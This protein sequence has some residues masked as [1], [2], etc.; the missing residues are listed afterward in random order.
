MELESRATQANTGGLNSSLVIAVL[1]DDA[2]TISLIKHLLAMSKQTRFDINVIS[3]AYF[4]ASQI[5]NTD[6]ILLDR[7]FGQRPYSNTVSDLA[8]ARVDKPL[9]AIIVLLDEAFLAD[10]LR[11]IASSV[12]TGVDDFILT[13]ELSL[14]RILELI[15]AQEPNSHVVTQPKPSMHAAQSPSTLASSTLGSSTHASSNLAPPV[16]AP[17]SPTTEREPAASPIVS[18]EAPIEKPYD[19]PLHPQ[20]Q[21]VH[22]LSIDLENRRIHLSQNEH[23][24]LMDEA[25]AIV[26]IEEWLELLDAEGAKS[27]HSMLQRA[28]EFLSVPK[29]ISCTIKSKTGIVYPA[30]ITEI[31]IKENGQGRVV[32][33][34]AQILIG[35]N[36]IASVSGTHTPY[37][38]FDNLDDIGSTPMVDKVW[39]NI[40]ESLPMMCMVL[41]QNGYIVRV[42]NSDRSSTHYFPEAHV[43]Q[44]LKD[45]FG[46]ES[47][48]NYVESI[49]KTLNTG[50][51]HQQ[52]IAYSS[53]NGA[54]WFDTFITKMRG[55]LG[56]SRQVVWTAF[57]ATA[58]RQAY[59]E[60]LKNHDSLT[61]TL[62]DA[63]VIFCQKDA[64]GRYQRVNRTFCETFN[65]RAEV[66][67]GRNDQDIFKGNTLDQITQQDKILAEQGG[68]ASFIQTETIN[69]QAIAI[70]WHKFALKGHSSN[71]VESIAAFG[72]VSNNIQ[73]P[74]TSPSPSA[75]TIANTE[76]EQFTATMEE[77]SG[78]I[79]QDTKAIIK[80]IVSYT[81]IAISQK[82]PGRETRV[83]EYLNQVVNASERARDLIIEASSQSDDNGDKQSIELKPLV[84]DIVHMLKPTLPM[85]INFQTDLESAYGKAL[86]SPVRFQR[87]VM[88]LLISARDSAQNSTTDQQNNVDRNNIL[89]SL[90]NQNYQDQTCTACNEAINGD[91]IA[92]EVKT[93]S[94]SLNADDVKKMVAAATKIKSQATESKQKSNNIIVMAHDN[95]GHVVIEY[96]QET[97]TLKLLFKQIAGNTGNDDDSSNHRQQTNADVTSLSNL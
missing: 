48:D 68:D 5:Y 33:I 15:T 83:I 93:T 40:A 24:I 4:N 82:T 53:L 26:S 58:G 74:I 95:D 92:L 27:F 63:P 62:N 38:G 10:D 85:S 14:K 39:M 69:G 3:S 80:N 9:P 50:K 86:V 90:K 70:Q 94:G 65:V 77:P 73:S 35:T 2:N 96:D 1:S 67:A 30:D 43:G 6:L 28:S 91:Y 89:L 55:D 79:G 51:A 56:I 7:E 44:T 71:K 64:D 25:D 12:K 42:I 23:S 47:L 54:R 81:E 22:L 34:N 61:D 72:F 49:N 36:I 17:A 20:S 87:I 29:S 78:A 31:Q 18:H 16:Y 32:G 84:R 66:V 11:L 8:Q 60:L 75:T 97:I 57:D 45:V 19:E 88:Q 76:E 59:Q 41:D 21:L 13:S 52:T 46:I 37:A